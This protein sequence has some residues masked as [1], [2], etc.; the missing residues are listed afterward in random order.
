MTTPIPQVDDTNYLQHCLLIVLELD[1]TTYYLTSNRRPLVF[2]GNVFN[3]LGW[4]LQVSDVQSDIKTNNGDI[5]IALSG[6]PESL[7]N[8][9][10]TTPIKGG[11]VS[12]ARAF[13]KGAILQAYPRY[14]GVIT[15]YAIE[16]QDDYLAR[17]RSYTVTITC[18]NINT[19]ME[20]RV[21]GQRTN[22]SDRKKFY[23][24]DISFDRTKDLQ[25]VNFDFGKKYTGGSGY[26]GA[27][28]PGG[29]G[30]FPGF[31]GGGGFGGG[32]FDNF[33]TN[34]R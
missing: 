34:E 10:L 14:Y 7:V 6:I 22:G 19:L 17:D 31:P 16:E 2:G 25:N 23:P 26:G 3:A 33:N 28:S 32:G 27:Y 24:G 8:A 20:N 30:I 4:L 9:V 11:R 5:S 18:A 21:S 12:V 13:Q 29:P 15:N 1:D